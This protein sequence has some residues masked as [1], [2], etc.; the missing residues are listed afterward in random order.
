MKICA[1]K[2]MSL[3][4]SIRH[5]VVALIISFF[6][7]NIMVSISLGVYQ[8]HVY[9]DR[10]VMDISQRII[11]IIENYYNGEESLVFIG[12]WLRSYFLRELDIS[13]R[14][15][16]RNN[17]LMRNM[18]EGYSDQ[19]IRSHGMMMR[20]KGETQT[21][22]S[23]GKIIIESGSS[24]LELSLP[25][26]W[27]D[28]DQRPEFL[29]RE[30]KSLLSPMRKQSAFVIFNAD[31]IPI[32]SYPRGNITIPKGGR[33]LIPKIE[34]YIET[35]K[36]DTSRTAG[37]VNLEQRQVKRLAPFTYIA[38]LLSHSDQL[39]GFFLLQGVTEPKLEGLQRSIFQMI[40]LV[41][42]LN[43]L[44]V[45]IA[46]LL[47][48]RFYLPR[49]FRPLEILS[50]AVTQVS[51]G[52][53]DTRI[54]ELPRETELAMLTSD[55]NQMAENLAR[56]T[57]LREEQSRDLAHELRTPL[58]IMRGELELIQEGV[59]EADK[60]RIASLHDEVLQLQYLVQDLETIY[61]KQEK[62]FALKRQELQIE[63][64]GLRAYK[65]FEA[66]ARKRNIQ[67]D[68]KLDSQLAGQE[69]FLDAERIH[70]V[71]SNL[72]VNA[73]RHT[74]VGGKIEISC[75]SAHV[76]GSDEETLV[77]FSVADSG[78]GISA[79]LREKVF[80]RLYSQDSEAK[81]RLGHR[82]LGLNIAKS[83]VEAHK[84][85]IWVEESALGGAC[86]S[87][88]IPRNKERA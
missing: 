75:F 69:C 79:E 22:S 37:Y 16:M 38:P 82:G 43:A 67:L 26:S 76:N 86:F 51:Q 64:V 36:Q 19:G 39:T 63:S 27:E 25:R 46:G 83:I 15:V 49:L 21:D 55:F 47:L 33:R 40:L 62:G 35:I 20:Q 23:G 74:P 1:R 53:F 2:S 77:G 66:S 10:F 34:D 29:P 58:T 6:V 45:I 88:V 71:F 8:T 4:G 72:L 84:G 17:D 78:P 81:H 5:L 41:S 11:S 28:P 9:T 70:Q 42:G 13:R 60:N 68:F 32:S 87:F 59:Y 73:L 57:G 54:K 7:L 24:R 14:S 31:G 3:K 65:A 61:T 50:E 48:S 44:V 12:S 52:A 18:M 30:N 85:R 56:E 80:E